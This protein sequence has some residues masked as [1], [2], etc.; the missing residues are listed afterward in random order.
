MNGWKE[1]NDPILT[2][3]RRSRQALALLH[4]LFGLTVITIKHAAQ[5]T[6]LSLKAANDLVKIFVEKG[7]LVETTG[8][9]RNRM[10]LFKEYMNMF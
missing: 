4:G 5:I 6:G 10:F 7:I 2:M 8:Y 3:G 1:K 9:L